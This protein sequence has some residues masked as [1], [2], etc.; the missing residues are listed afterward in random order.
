M[1][2]DPKL[3]ID[4]ATI[5]EEGSFTRAAQRLRVAQPWLSVRI[6]KLEE[7]VGYRLFDRSTRRMLL[8]EP[9]AE[10][11]E[12]ARNVA[13]A[14][15]AA[16]RLALQLGRRS[17]TV[18]RIGAPPYSKIIRERRELIGEF[19]L[20]HPNVSLEIEIGWSLALLDR[21]A[22]GDID[23]A[24]IMGDTEAVGFEK[25]VLKWF[26]V[27][28]SLAHDHPWAKLSSISPE[29]T[30]GQPIEVFIR[31]LNPG[32]WDQLYAPLIEVGADV[33][34][35]PELAEG[36]PDRMRSPEA[37]AAYLDFGAD[38][39]GLAEIVRIP[40]ATPAIVPFQLL[41]HNAAP[42]KVGEEFWQFA[43]FRSGQG[44]SSL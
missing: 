28:L 16:E 8:T 7:I 11:F 30:V 27:A 39:P 2:I 33:I 42:S 4:F 14:A 44:Q 10:L 9:G 3:M 31:N 24:F 23:L 32:L 5:A 17:R 29:R 6:H 1:P 41:R 15:E 18:L 22:R 34:E 12:A 40:L 21:L 43:H 26:G 13:K 36:A 20:A 37:V 19:A 25:V 38:D 35:V